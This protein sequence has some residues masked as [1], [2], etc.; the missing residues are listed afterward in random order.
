MVQLT[1]AQ[2]NKELNYL[3]ENY[4]RLTI[5]TA[6]YLVEK[7]RLQDQKTKLLKLDDKSLA[8]IETQ[9]KNYKSSTLKNKFTKTNGNAIQES[10]KFMVDEE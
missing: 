9:K 6:Q 2:I 1:I 3:E 7:K 10:G 5:K 8:V 4:Q